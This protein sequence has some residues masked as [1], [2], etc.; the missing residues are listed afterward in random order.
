LIKS[1]S[2]N[3]ACFEAVLKD[4]DTDAPML[5]IVKTYGVQP[6]SYDLICEIAVENL[7]GRPFSI[8][9]QIQ[10]PGGISQEDIRQ[11]TRKIITAYSKGNGIETRLLNSTEIRGLEQKKIRPSA[12]F[13]SSLR[14]LFGKS[15]NPDIK[16][17][18]F[19]RQNDTNIAW[20]ASTNKYFA[21]I[22]RPVQDETT[23]STGVFFSRAVFY[24][25][26]LLEKSPAQQA[27]ASFLLETSRRS[28]CGWLRRMK[29]EA[30]NL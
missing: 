25:T 13:F 19:L 8:Q 11:D 9:M 20:A 27:G 29:E 7:S 6:G 5:R 22:V 24:D 17:N 26:H 12:G 1:P 23:E 16:L 30:A 4:A 18:Q 21:A 2:A 15:E 14:N 10:G 3:E 28:R